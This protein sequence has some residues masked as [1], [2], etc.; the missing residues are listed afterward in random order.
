MNPEIFYRMQVDN[1]TPKDSSQ[2]SLEESLQVIFRKDSTNYF[3]HE[4]M[5]KPL[6]PLLESKG[7]WITFGDGS[8]GSDAHWLEEHGQWV[9]ATD[10]QDETLKVAQAKGLIQRYSAENAER[11]SF[12]DNEFDWSFCK[13]AFHH[14]PRGPVAFYEMMRVS[15]YGAVFIEPIDTEPTSWLGHLALAL[16]EYRYGHEYN[17]EPSGNFIYT[18]SRR[19]VEKMMLGVGLR[20]YAFHHLTDHYIRGVEQEIYPGP[21]AEKIM[22]YIN[23]YEKKKKLMSLSGSV[24]VFVVFKNAP[25]SQTELEKN[26]FRFFTL[27]ENPYLKG[28]P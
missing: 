6:L 10:I 25:H 13:E 17:F 4:R 7:R 18:L 2:E 21:L 28:T 8:Y 22:T 5:R 26:G 11:V 20:H 16:R 1:H 9:M 23:K 19:E 12:K 24:G 14:M 27:P 3:R 15:R